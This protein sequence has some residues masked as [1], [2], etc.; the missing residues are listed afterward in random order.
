MVN[1]QEYG[2]EL[3]F[4]QYVFTLEGFLWLEKDFIL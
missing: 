1:I 4:T 2:T 3:Q